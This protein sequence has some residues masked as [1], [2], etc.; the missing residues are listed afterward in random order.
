M[1][2]RYTISRQDRVIR[3]V[4]TGIISAPDLHHLIDSLLADPE[5]GPG[6]RGLYDASEAEPDISILQLA[7]VAAKVRELLKRGLGRIAIVAQSRATYRVSKTFTVLAQAIG[8]DVD[9]FTDLTDA[10]DWLEEASGSSDSGEKPLT[11]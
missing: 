3:A 7:E 10:E 9:V 11:H 6:L 5:L 4:A 8:I 2:I 1:P